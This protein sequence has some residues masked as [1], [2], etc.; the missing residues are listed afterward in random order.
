M[1]N[2]FSQ[3]LHL[4]AEFLELVAHRLQFPAGP[5]CGLGGFGVRRM[6]IAGGAF[7]GVMFTFDLGGPL[8]DVAGLLGKPGEGEMLGR[9]VEMAD[10]G[11][12]RQGLR[13]TTSRFFAAFRYGAALGRRGSFAGTFRIG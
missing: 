1:G 6:G 13:L 9:L 5:R 11:F 10:A 2:F 4:A 7:P 12:Q 3:A 8:A